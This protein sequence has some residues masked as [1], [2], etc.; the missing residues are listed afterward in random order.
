MLHALLMRSCLV[1][2]Q[3][4][5]MKTQLSLLYFFSVLRNELKNSKQLLF[6]NFL[7][8]SLNIKHSNAT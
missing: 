7:I 6:Q 5:D 1:P 2:L 3:L 8:F 4:G